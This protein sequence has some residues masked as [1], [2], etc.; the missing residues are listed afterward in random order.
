MNQ[1]SDVLRQSWGEGFSQKQLEYVRNHFGLTKIELDHLL[2][3]N[4]KY[5]KNSALLLKKIMPNKK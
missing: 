2:M 3:L 5:H 4:L 1:N